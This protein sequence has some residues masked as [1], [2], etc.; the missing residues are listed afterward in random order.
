MGKLY[1]AG[2]GL[3]NAEKMTEFDKSVCKIAKELC[4]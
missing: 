4:L 1:A 3:G 2:F